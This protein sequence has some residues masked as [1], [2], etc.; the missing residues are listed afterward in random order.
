MDLYCA[1]TYE[2]PASGRRETYDWQPAG[3]DEP[4]YDNHIGRVL[5]THYYSI[6]DLFNDDVMLIDPNP[7][8]KPK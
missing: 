1:E 7:D 4:D 3:R 2:C 8:E 6:P 5:E